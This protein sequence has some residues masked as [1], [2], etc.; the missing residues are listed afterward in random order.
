M[1]CAGK[2]VVAGPRAGEA[3]FKVEGTA[4]AKPEKWENQ[5]ILAL[6]LC[7]EIRTLGHVGML[8]RSAGWLVRSSVSQARGSA[9]PRGMM[10][11][12][13]SFSAENKVLSCAL[14]GPLAAAWRRAGRMS[15]GGNAFFSWP[16]GH[17]KTPITALASPQRRPVLATSSVSAVSPKELICFE[18][19]KL[20][21]MPLSHRASAWPPL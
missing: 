16:P 4:S 10:G 12:K 9:L 21:H 19:L 1:G 3:A 2:Q 11:G 18:D 14:V 7:R 15:P 5:A 8:A 13:A 6:G 20:D 17:P